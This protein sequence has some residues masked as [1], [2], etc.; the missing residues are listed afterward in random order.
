[1][2]STVTL[3]SVLIQALG[4]GTAD[5]KQAILPDA[6]E[7]SCEQY[8]LLTSQRSGSSW[9]CQVL[10][11][12]DGMV[13]GRKPN[14]IESPAEGKVQEMMIKYSPSQLM[15]HQNLTHADVSWGMWE[16]DLNQTFSTLREEGCAGHAGSGSA[17]VGFKLMYDQV[18]YHLVPQ[19]LLYL[20]KHKVTVLHMVREASV[21]RLASSG[22]SHG[23]MHSNDAN[24]VASHEADPWEWHE[25]TEDN[26]RAIER[27][28]EAWA[29]LLRLNPKIRYHY[30]AYE[31]LI[32][33]QR[34]A[35]FRELALFAGAP[36]PIL[37]PFE[38][39]PGELVALHEPTCEQRVKKYAQ[40]A[41]RLAGTRTL[42][43]CLTLAAHPLGHLP[44]EFGEPSP[45]WGVGSGGA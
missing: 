10:D 29:N 39:V 13:C 26:I 36:G 1:M 19:F 33:P 44:A 15:P 37:S 20:R 8:V 4:K 14:A 42:V 25:K 6:S 12:Q 11:A 9:T 35:Y 21:L 2:L 23:L 45:F 28:N 27:L 30:V 18:P 16:A 22:Q 43:A 7:S 3:L 34:D 5:Q 41:D 24:E 40:L 17:T 32:S 38:N 31:Q